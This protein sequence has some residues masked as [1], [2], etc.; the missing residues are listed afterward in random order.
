MPKAKKQ[1]ANNEKKQE[2]PG[3]KHRRVSEGEN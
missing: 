3:N 2:N 1:P